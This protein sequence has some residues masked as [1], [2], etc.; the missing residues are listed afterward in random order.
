MDIDCV[1]VPSMLEW[2]ELSVENTEMR[3]ESGYDD[4]NGCLGGPQRSGTSGY[5]FQNFQARKM[6]CRMES[7]S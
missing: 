4:A 6:S 3:C 5:G 1:N 2:F 7:T